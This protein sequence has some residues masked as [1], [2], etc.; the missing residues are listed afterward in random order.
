MVLTPIYGDQFS[1]GFAVE[2]RNIGRIIDFNQ[3]VKMNLKDI[4]M[5]VLHTNY[6]MKAL[7]VSKIFNDRESKPLDTAMDSSNMVGRTCF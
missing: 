1:N 3:I 5:E 4:I 7:E 6:T 2:N